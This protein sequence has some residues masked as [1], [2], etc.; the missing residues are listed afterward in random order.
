MTNLQTHLPLRGHFTY[1]ETLH[2]LAHFITR[3]SSPYLKVT[4][5][6]DKVTLEGTIPDEIHNL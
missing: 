3:E 1:R 5:S 4:S 2:P 6:V